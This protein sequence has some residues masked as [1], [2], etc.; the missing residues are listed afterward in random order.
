MN[1]PANEEFAAN[2]EAYDL[3]SVS[4]QDLS[5]TILIKTD[6]LNS[7]ARILQCSANSAV[8]LLMRGS[9]EQES[10]PRLSKNPYQDRRW[11]RSWA[12]SGG[13]G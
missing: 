2:E 6:A 5:K 13:T 7:R 4:F 11:E 10:N 9:E 8:T 12:K 1:G 3:I